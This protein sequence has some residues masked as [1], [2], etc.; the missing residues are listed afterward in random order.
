MHKLTSGDAGAAAF[1][2]GPAQLFADA[3]MAP[4]T[5]DDDSD[6]QVHDD[7]EVTAR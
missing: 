6:D 7:A 4:G 2:H 5:A 1:L 3:A